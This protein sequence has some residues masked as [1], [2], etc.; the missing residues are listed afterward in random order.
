MGNRRRLETPLRRVA[1]VAWERP[2]P[3]L[4]GGA[5]PN[6]HIAIYPPTDLPDCYVE[7]EKQDAD[8]DIKD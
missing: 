5:P 2:G 7:S 8:W 6:P 3:H 1:L 4:P